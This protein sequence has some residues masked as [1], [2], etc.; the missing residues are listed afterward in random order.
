MWRAQQA[1]TQEQS[2]VVWGCVE[3]QNACEGMFWELHVHVGEQVALAQFQ[4]G[5]LIEYIMQLT[6]FHLQCIESFQ[7]HVQCT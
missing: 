1:L 5:H 6:T 4:N 2:V 3:E 7:A